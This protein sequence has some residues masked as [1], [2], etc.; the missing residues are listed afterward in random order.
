[1]TG[2]SGN[3]RSGSLLICAAPEEGRRQPQQ[4]ALPPER[5][6]W[7]QGRWPGTTVASASLGELT[8]KANTQAISGCSSVVVL[9]RGEN[10]LGPYLALTIQI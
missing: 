9:W 2:R 6:T 1:M 5:G 3:G 7:R 8:A 10:L 4:P